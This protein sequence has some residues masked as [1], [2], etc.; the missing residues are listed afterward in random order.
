MT[1]W[2]APQHARFRVHEATRPM[3]LFE[4]RQ[5]AE[6]PL[7]PGHVMPGAEFSAYGRKG[8]DV[9]ESNPTM[10]SDTRFVRQRN[11]RE[12]VTEAF[13]RKVG[14]Q[15]RIQ[16]APDALAL[17]FRIDIRRDFDRPPIRRPLAMG[18]SVSVTQAAAVL[19]GD[20]PL[21]AVDCL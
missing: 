18:G 10:Q 19:L 12:C 11:S 17:V 5:I 21:P 2:F 20:K 14:K 13:M 6:A 16:Q 3:N 7:K 1:G 4:R 9:L 15:S 8:A